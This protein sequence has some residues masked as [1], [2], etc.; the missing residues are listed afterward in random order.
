ME[1]LQPLDP[2]VRASLH[3]FVRSRATTAEAYAGDRVLF[4]CAMSSLPYRPATNPRRIAYLSYS[5][6]EFDSRS[7][8]MAR[9]A[10][11]AGDA[12]TIYARWEPGLALEEERPGYRI[13]RVPFELRMAIPGLRANGRRRLT[14]RLAGWTAA[15]GAPQAAATISRPIPSNAPVTGLAAR[16]RETKLARA[17]TLRRPLAEG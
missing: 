4:G 11:E 12:V 17:A 7:H 14:K 5:T 6:A 2:I 9:S 10:V 15:A 8:R 1:R 3:P 16:S 13:V